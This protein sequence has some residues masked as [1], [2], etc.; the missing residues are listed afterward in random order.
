M[1]RSAEAT[2]RRAEKR[3]RSVQDQRKADARD[4]EKGDEREEESRK[5]SNPEGTIKRTAKP[6]V[7]VEKKH[8]TPGVSTSTRK[9]AIVSGPSVD[10]D[11]DVV[12]AGGGLEKYQQILT[13]LLGGEKNN[14]SGTET[15]NTSKSSKKQVAAKRGIDPALSEPG[16]WI[17][18]GCGNHN[19]ASRHACHSKTCDRTRPAGVPVPPRYRHPAPRDGAHAST[20]DRRHDPSTSKT[21]QWAKQ[22][23]TETLEKNQDLRQRYR[24]TGGEGMEEG[25]AARARL[26]LERDARKKQKKDARKRGK[27]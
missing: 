22:A 16:A 15:T 20:K 9:N 23:G 7:R 8:V 18:V 5:R 11:A 10:P 27:G 12:T 17:C 26:L 2:K 1:V 19:F 3:K 13:G 24:E 21:L 14:N 25:D 4:A 6:K